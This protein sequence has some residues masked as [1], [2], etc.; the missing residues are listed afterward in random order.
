LADNHGSDGPD[1]PPR[2]N[3]V[4][5]DAVNLVTV[6][7]PTFR[8]HELLKHALRSVRAQ[9]YR[10]LQVVV[11]DDDNDPATGEIVSKAFAGATGLESEFLR[12]ANLGASAARNRGLAAARGR[13]IQFLDDDDELFPDKIAE[14]TAFL[15]ESGADIVFGDWT[16]G[17]DVA[18]ARR[19]PARESGN[20]FV[21][22]TAGGWIPAFS[23]LCRVQSCRSVG[24]WDTGIRFNDDFDFFLRLAATGASFRHQP[25]NTGFYRWHAGPRLSV[26]A[27]V[28]RATANVAIVAAAEQLRRDC[29]GIGLAEM[30]ALLVFWRKI[31]TEASGEQ[32]D[33]CLAKIERLRRD[34]NEP[35]SAAEIVFGPRIYYALQAI[36]GPVHWARS[37]AHALLPLGARRAMR[38]W[39]NRFR[40]ALRFARLKV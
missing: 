25:L 21:C 40:N 3:L 29:V 35:A 9:T 30:K 10:P 32:F 7:I 19:F 2:Q 20:H 12:Q 36:G 13:F 4:R 5:P 24:G 38:R 1:K 39:E 17:Q 18:A 16:Q 22:L 23:Y 33:A 11:V 27:K 8:R 15:E 31:A 6:V 26:E 28:E 14:Q 34:L 37:L